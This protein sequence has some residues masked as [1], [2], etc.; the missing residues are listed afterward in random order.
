MKSTKSK[1]NRYKNIHTIPILPATPHTHFLLTKIPRKQHF[2][3]RLIFSSVIKNGIPSHSN[4]YLEIKPEDCQ[5]CSCVSWGQQYLSSLVFGR[6]GGDSEGLGSSQ[7]LLSHMGALCSVDCF[8]FWSPLPRQGE[9]PQASQGRGYTQ[10][11]ISS[12]QTEGNGTWLWSQRLDVQCCC[13]QGCV[14]R[15]SRLL[16]LFSARCCIKC[17]PS[18]PG[19]DPQL[20]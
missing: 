16:F 14:S 5:K 2:V 4:S 9:Q 3:S 6:G 19:L 13:E 12:L 17:F 1:Q 18:G 11:G 20:Q 10:A 15:L 7:L 8:L